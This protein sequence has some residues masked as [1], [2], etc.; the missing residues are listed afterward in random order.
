[1]R[2]IYVGGY[3]SLVGGADTEL[4]SLIDLWRLHG[5]DVHLVPMFP[6]DAS[7]RAKCDSRGCT[8]HEYTPAIFKDKV[9]VSL[10]NGE[11]LKR[12]PAIHAAGRPA[13]VVW[14][15]CMTWLFNDERTAHAAGLID[16]HV[17]QS[18]YQRK[19]LVAELSAIA[20]VRELHGYR[21]YYAPSPDLFQP[22]PHGQSWNVGRI[23]RDDP[24]KFAADTWR[25]F[26]RVLAPR[27][28]K[29]FVLGFSDKVK[30]KI[31]E[32]AGLDYQWWTPGSVPATDVYRRLHCLIHKTGGSRENWPRVILES[33]A[34]GVV[35]I[36]ERDYG[37]LD[38]VID[39][40]TGYLCSS[41]DEMA[42]RASVL[43]FDDD[44]RMR[45][46]NNARNYLSE[47]CNKERCWKPWANLLG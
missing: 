4:D 35:P 30:A 26:E 8:T 36:V 14:A 47:L 34:H 40:V 16:Y 38:M 7:M 31:G 41:S 33:Y 19:R 9:V 42:Y 20:P 28:K 24:A 32:P 46:V 10:C 39:G 2:E 21:P 11:F 37:H 5:V 23:S 17:Y 43:A 6:P 12:L 1:M 25:I 45:L 44:L 27:G 13:A 29:V 3:P 22:L 18:N 15:N